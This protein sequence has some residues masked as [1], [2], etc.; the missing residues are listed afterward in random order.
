MTNHPYAE[1]TAP[2]LQ[3][4]IE[5]VQQGEHPIGTG[6]CRDIPYRAGPVPRVYGDDWRR[7]YEAMG[8]A[9]TAEKRAARVQG[10][11]DR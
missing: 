8:L 5:W 3:T 10:M 2:D 9:M 1:P 6:I 4:Y 7:G 11:R